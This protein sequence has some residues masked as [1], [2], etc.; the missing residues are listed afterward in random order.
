MKY[1]FCILIEVVVTWENTLVQTIPLK[2][3][4]PIVCKFTSIKKNKQYRGREFPLRQKQELWSMVPIPLEV[5]YLV[6]VFK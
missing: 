6:P 2:Y 3:A 4:Y 5:P 1:S